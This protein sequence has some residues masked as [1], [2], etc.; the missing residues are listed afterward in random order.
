VLVVSGGLQVHTRRV[1][2]R[3]SVAAGAL[4]PA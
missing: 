1:R 2:R 4:V 3:E